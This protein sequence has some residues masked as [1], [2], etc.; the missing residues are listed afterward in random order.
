MRKIMKLHLIILMFLLNAFYLQ[1]AELTIEGYG[2]DKMSPT[3]NYDKDKMFMV[4]TAKTQNFTNLGIR[5]I[6]SC[7][8]TVEI[9]NGVQNQNI[10]CESKNEYGNFYIVTNKTV[11]DTQASVQKFIFAAGTGI[12][13]EF[14][15]AVCTGAYSG[16]QESH[17]MWKGKCKVPDSVMENAKNR[18]MNFKKEN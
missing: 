10:M 15:G 18:M 3:Y 12:W 13:T 8:G 16:A 11:G 7:G 14:V 1:S 2:T 9:I 4:W 6:G 5:S 17:F